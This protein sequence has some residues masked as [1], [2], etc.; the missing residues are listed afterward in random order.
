VVK[1]GDHRGELTLLA[2]QYAERLMEL[3][4]AGWAEGGLP[5]S[6]QSSGTATWVIKHAKAEPGSVLGR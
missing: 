1:E 5:L 4:G 2:N 6:F 3:H